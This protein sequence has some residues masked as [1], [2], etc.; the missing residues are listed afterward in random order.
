MVA[1]VEHFKTN[2]PGSELK[3]CFCA[4]RAVIV[5]ASAWHQIRRHKAFLQE[6]RRAVQ[7]Q[8]GLKMV[9][10]QAGLQFAQCPRR[11][12]GTLQQSGERG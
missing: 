12:R 9:V 1:E 4:E 6:T 10:I 5:P 2:I 3:V 7:I 8:S 11:Q